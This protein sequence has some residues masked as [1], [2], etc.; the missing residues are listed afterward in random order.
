M[1]RRPDC[2][3][4]VSIWGLIALLAAAA[5]A[6]GALPP[7]G[8]PTGPAFPPR[9]FLLRGVRVFDGE[10]VL[11]SAD[12][13]VRGGKIAAVLPRDPE[14]AGTGDAGQQLLKRP[15]LAQVTGQNRG[16]ERLPLRGGPPIA[17]PRLVNREQVLAALQVAR[18]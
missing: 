15:R 2:S 9:D 10:Q 4:L 1:A 5:L 11:A 13:L 12:V 17:H 14:G 3:R 18:R 6:A 16:L 7:S 8:A